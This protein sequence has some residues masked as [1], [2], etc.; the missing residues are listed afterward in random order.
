MKE[1][2]QVCYLLLK[3]GAGTG[4]FSSGKHPKVYPVEPD[5]ILL[6]NTK[7]FSR[8]L[9]FPF[10]IAPMIDEGFGS[11]NY[12]FFFRLNNYSRVDAEA[13]R[14][15]ESIIFSA[16]FLY[17]SPIGDNEGEL[18]FRFPRPQNDDSINYEEIV[19]AEEEISPPWERQFYYSGSA[20]RS[21]SLF[22][23]FIIAEILSVAQVCLK[24]ANL[25][26]SLA[27][28]HESTKRFSINSVDIEEAL[29]N[30]SREAINM[31]EQNDWENSAQNAFKAIEAL[32]GDPPGDNEKFFRKLRETGINPHSLV[33]YEE[34]KPIYQAI[35]DL[36]KLRDKKAAHGST[37]NRCIKLSEMLDC[38]GCREEVVALSVENLLGRKICLEA[39]RE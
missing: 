16:S 6:K 7:D 15:C 35:R 10:W 36:G 30:K 22:P 18:F 14:I 4:V 3:L 32:I 39:R 11:N 23:D 24:H 33:G 37:I 20:I 25:L 34:K 13:R 8:L 26:Q 21:Y 31:L 5:P 38:Q 19:K 27:F 9:G 17:E 29:T 12:R 1:E 28:L 2:Q